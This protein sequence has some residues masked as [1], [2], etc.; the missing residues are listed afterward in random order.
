V[1]RVESGVTDVTNAD[2]LGQVF[3]ALGAAD[4]DA[5]D[6][7]Y[8][9]DYV[10]ELPYAKPDPVRVEGRAPVQEYLRGAFGVFRFELALTGVHELVN[11]DL[12]AEYTSEGTVIPTGRRYAN[13]YVGLW[14]FR[15]GRVSATRE[16]YDPLVAAEAA[17]GL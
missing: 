16:W 4:V 1:G 7:L 17:T 2:L 6:D 11:G 5:L 12:M 10:L 9:D 8:T 3:E 14:R 15:D 13:A